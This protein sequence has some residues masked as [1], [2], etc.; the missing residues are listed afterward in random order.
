[1]QSTPSGEHV[2]RQRTISDSYEADPMIKNFFFLLFAFLILAGCTPKTDSPDSADEPQR[3]RYI[4]A[5]DISSEKE[6][7]RTKYGKSGLEVYELGIGPVYDG[8]LILGTSDEDRKLFVSAVDIATGKELWMTEVPGEK[9]QSFAPLVQTVFL[10]RRGVVGQLDPT[11]GRLAEKSRELLGKPLAF[12]DGTVFSA[13]QSEVL[14][15]KTASWEEDWSAEIAGVSG[16]IVTESG[17]LV[18]R[19]PNGCQALTP[20]GEPLWELKTSFAPARLAKQGSTLFLATA[21]PRLFA[22][23]SKTGE[24]LWEQ[25]W[26]GQENF[27]DTLQVG[28]KLVLNMVGDSILALDISTGEEKWKVPRG[29]GDYIIDPTT[30]SLFCDNGLT[31]EVVR[32][33]L[34]DGKELSRW[35]MDVNVTDLLV[36][37]DKLI[38]EAV[39][40]PAEDD[41]G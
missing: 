20:G 39:D 15:L 13:I 27:W 10:A 11:T 17:D 24:K 37:G 12:A 16:G 9:D 1:M 14:A 41:P 33:S 31:D 21:E 5:Y 4:I 7:Y 25:G 30:E 23:D 19:N 40:K 28:E 2:K 32:Y 8:K 34:K 26:K 35:K 3:F 18:V 36:D 22:L 38:L 6:L 29:M